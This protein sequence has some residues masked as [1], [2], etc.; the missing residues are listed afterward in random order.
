MPANYLTGQLNIVQAYTLVLMETQ[1]L[2]KTDIV[3]ELA[4]DFSCSSYTLQR[5]NDW[6][7]GRAPLPKNV[8]EHMMK[9]VTSVH[10]FATLSADD[11]AKCL[12]FP[13]RKTG[14]K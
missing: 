5:L 2:T 9:E 11:K 14:E 1:E 7:K 12:A 10:E 6:L 8:Y 3:N 4:V 13:L